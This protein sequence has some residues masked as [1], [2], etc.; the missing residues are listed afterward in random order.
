MWDLIGLVGCGWCVDGWVDG[1]VL[2]ER[3]DTSVKGRKGRL[4]A[5]ESHRKELTLR[6]IFDQYAF[7]TYKSKVAII[8]TNSQT[9]KS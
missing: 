7:V 2:L 5:S 4:S 9:K 6:R 1:W 8:S 3:N